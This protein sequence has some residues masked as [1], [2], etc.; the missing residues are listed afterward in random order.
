MTGAWASCL[1]GVA[2]LA[3]GCVSAEGVEPRDPFEVLSTADAPAG[4]VVSA[5]DLEPMSAGAAT[6]EDVETGVRFEIRTDAA[7]PDVPASLPAIMPASR[8]NTA[9]VVSGSRYLRASV[10]DD[11]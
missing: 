4:T 6:W 7:A 5:A 3:A 2:V 1:A 11:D 8:A 10:R 9:D